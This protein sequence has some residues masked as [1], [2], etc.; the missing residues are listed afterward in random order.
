MRI[1]V[2]RSEAQATSEAPGSRIQAR[3]NAAPFVQA[4]L[5]KGNVLTEAVS[6]VGEYALMRAKAD[7]EV[8][9]SEAMLAADE[10]MR[11]LAEDLSKNGRLEDL[12]NEN[13]AWRTRSKDIRDR[14]ADNLSSRSMTD[15]F[16]SRFNQQE[17]TLRFQLRD[18][19]Q[20]RMERQIA[21]AR[22][23]RMKSA[24]DSIANGTDIGMLNMVLTGVGV[25]TN[26]LEQFGL[27]NPEA[28]KAQEYSLLKDGTTRAAIKYLE[29]Q[30]L[31]IAAASR[32]HEALKTDDPSKIPDARGL[33]VYS[34][35]Q[36][37]D[38]VDRVAILKSVNGISEYVNGP[39]LEQ[40]QLQL[41]TQGEF[42]KANQS[43]SSAVSTLKS[44]GTIPDAEWAQV[45]AVITSAKEAGIDPGLVAAVETQYQ[46]A[47]F[48]RDLSNEVK[49]ATPLQVQNILTDLESG[50]TFGAAGLDTNRE[51]IAT[52]FLRSFKA[53]MQKA[54][55]ED[56][57]LSWG[58]QNGQ[59]RLQPIDTSFAQPMPEL[60]QARINDAV[61]V[62]DLYRPTPIGT[63][64]ATPVFLL[65]AERDQIAANFD[66]AAP[67]QKLQMISNINQSFGDY[68][69]S[70][71]AEI[72]PKVPA[73]GH[74]AGLLSDGQGATAEKVVTGL[75]LLAAGN[76]PDGATPQM[77][78]PFVREIVSSSLSFLPANVNA[79]LT[80][81]LNESA[82]AYY[83]GE[84]SRRGVID[85]DPALWQESV[86][87]VTGYDKATGRGGI[88]EVRGI[89]TML[90][91]TMTADDAENLL[92]KLA[93]K[94]L[95]T[96][97]WN[98]DLL[99]DTDTSEMLAEASDDDEY[100]TMVFGRDEQGRQV[101]ALTYG[102]Y[103]DNSF[104]V[105]TDA[106]GDTIT[107]TFEDLMELE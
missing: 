106:R 55:T 82:M 39:T 70:V 22:A 7:A 75:T 98:K 1:P 90:P 94:G 33:Y 91:P 58:N 62:R 54:I 10:E 56:G 37:L 25:D 63:P 102:Q 92:P 71:I 79:Q 72:A 69:S 6:Q 19:I 44:G 29:E 35:M 57:G 99:I 41:R 96:V 21:E 95:L 65:Q 51:Q 80:T 3:M 42:K 32:L 45:G 9:Y 52:E 15:A 83:T 12:T 107:F 60:A 64:S 36:K 50:T 84:A 11:L 105:M 16:N 23:Q 61:K 20:A 88:Q 31:S 28:L 78:E 59:V 104:A 66:A 77:T 68:A 47:S 87:A 103:G 46:D 97:P 86:L 73:M 18:S 76:K 81:A 100:K 8:Q 4:A 17:L 38:P 53:S 48:L 93:P 30:D 34:L 5:S 67:L 43:I 101:Y 14:L 2:F 89:Q 85:F 40:E 74:V 26:R 13:G 24:E 27:G 49:T